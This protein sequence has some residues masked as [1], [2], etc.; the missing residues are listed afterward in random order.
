MIAHLIFKYVVIYHDINFIK[1]DI[2]YQH[3]MMFGI[4][5]T[6]MIS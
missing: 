2:I 1:Y 4:L 6:P 3:H 5:I